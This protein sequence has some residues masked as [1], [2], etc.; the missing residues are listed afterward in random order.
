MFIFYSYTYLMKS[1]TT[2]FEKGFAD[3]CAVAQEVRDLFP[4]LL[5][6]GKAPRFKSSS[7]SLAVRAWRKG[8]KSYLLAV[9]RMRDELKGTVTL[10]EEFANAKP[11]MGEG[12]TKADGRVLSFALKPIGVAMLEL[13]GTN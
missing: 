4:V 3:V 1:P 13:D 12:F 6:D 2:P 7:L 11:I 9:N 8:S 5:S 10:D